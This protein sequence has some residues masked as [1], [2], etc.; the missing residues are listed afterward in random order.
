MAQDTPALRYRPSYEYDGEGGRQLVALGVGSTVWCDVILHSNKTQA[1][2]L[3][4]EDVV[5]DDILVLP[6]P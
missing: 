5:V 2:L 6:H 4:E 3:A 1:V